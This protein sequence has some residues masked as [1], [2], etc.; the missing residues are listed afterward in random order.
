MIDYFNGTLSSKTQNSVIIEV[1]G[2][3]YNVNVTIAT[4]EKLPREGQELK[5]YI[6]E[7]TGMYGGLISHYGFLSKDEREMFLLIKEEVPSTGAKKAMEYLDKISKS[8]ADFRNAVVSRD[9]S[10]LCSV[11]GFTKKTAEKLIAALK[12]KISGVAV[13]NS[14]KWIGISENENMSEAIAGLV[15]LGYKEFQARETVSKIVKN[16]E[17]KSVENIIKEALKYL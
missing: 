4:S 8:F 11:F 7:S 3:G 2:I 12:D 9:I 10:M 17:E 1:S 5:L 15:A 6:V 14:A 16:S 13:S